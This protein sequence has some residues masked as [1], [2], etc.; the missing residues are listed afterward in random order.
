M[1]FKTLDNFN[2]QRYG[3]AFR[4]IED[5]DTADVIFLYQSTAD[6][7]VAD[8]HY[9]K[10][11][12]FS[13]YVHCLGHGCPACNKGIRVQTKLF[14]PLY[15]LNTKQIEFWDRTPR[16]EPQLQSDVFRKYPNPSEVVFRITRKG[17][18][19]DIN[20]TYEIQAV[21]RNNFMTVDQIL[22][23]ANVKAPGHYEK[24]CKSMGANEMSEILNS[25]NGGGAASELPEYSAY[26]ATPRA[27]I[28]QPEVV[29]PELSAPP[30]DLPELPPFDGGTVVAN[31]VPAL[32]DV[33]SAA[34]AADA[35]VADEELS[36][37]EF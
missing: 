23:A 2:E 10:S 16:M 20:T 29:A 30:E 26:G 8:T 7:L 5:G 4:L 15:N 1:A 21:N 6:V 36:E 14:I 33:P 3:S 24:I 37:P 28:P 31:D 11:T 13:G 12:D 32:A 9:L 27:E 19:G 35:P 18:S 17:A 22:A 25:N 34:Q